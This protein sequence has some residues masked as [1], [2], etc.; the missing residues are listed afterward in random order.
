MTTILFYNDF[1]PSLPQPLPD[2]PRS[3]QL[4]F[5]R[6]RLSEAELVVFHLPT[7]TEPITTGKRPGQQ[8]VAWSMESDVNCPLLADPTFMQQFDLT[9]TY[10]RDASVWTPYFGPDTLACLSTP[11]QPK[12]EQAPAV[13]FASN[14]C[15]Y[16]GRNTYTAALMRYL[17]VDSYGR[18]LRNR[19][20]ERDEGRE[21]KLETIARYRFT[22]AF[23]NS[24]SQDYVTEKFFEPL[25]AGSVPVYLGAPNIAEF[26]PAD[27]C[28]INVAD[29]Q[30]PAHL[31][32]YL[33]LLTEHPELYERYLSWKPQGLRDSFVKMVERTTVH[34]LCR[35]AALAE[36]L[37]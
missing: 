13:Y 21:S 30:G 2:C 22:L 8:W 3:Y 19:T 25:I 15:D 29:F 5:D 10:R 12:T 11:P 37:V 28:F 7:L 23:E 6:G 14:F 31:A 9:M 20:L 36:R 18:C 17:K 33:Q 34:P 1:W 26:S 16:S 4:T 32:G 35:L 24:V 27:H